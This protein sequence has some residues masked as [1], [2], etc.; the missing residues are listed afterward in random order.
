MEVGLSTASFFG[1]Y[2]LEDIPARIH[3]IGADV[4]E[5]FLN[6]FSEYQPSFIELLRA[7]ILEEGLRVFGVHPMSVQFESQLFSIYTRQRTDAEELFEQVLRAGARLGATCYVMHGPAGMY[8]AAKNVQLERIGPMLQKLCE[9]AGEHG[10][11]IA[12]ENVSWC[13]FSRPEVGKELLAATGADDLRFTLDVKQAAR[14]GYAPED[15]VRAMGG[16]LMNVHLC[17]YLLREGGGIYPRLPGK[18]VCDYT[19]LRAALQEVNYK[20]PAFLE[21]YSDLYEEEEALQESFAYVRHCLK[22]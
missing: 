1:K 4:C 19:A 8:G 17:D 11:T 6:T 21:V 15:Y 20:G 9:R 16:R 5:V 7:R 14:S 10:I 3:A 2:D 13:L 18:G 12:W 22:T